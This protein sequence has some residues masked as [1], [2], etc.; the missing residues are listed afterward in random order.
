MKMSEVGGM[1][2]AKRTR[3]SFDNEFRNNAIRYVQDHSDLTIKEAAL[4]LGVGKSTLTRW[5]SEAKHS[6][7]GIVEMRGT[8]NFA[9]D[10][11]KEIAQLKREL[12]DTKDALDVLKKAISILGK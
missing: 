11:T 2:M 5:M 4:N 12:R 10:E 8:G 9:S 7:N 1:K 6:E 3:K